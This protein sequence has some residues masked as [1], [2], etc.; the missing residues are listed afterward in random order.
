MISFKT[1][2]KIR[3][4]EWENT[5]LS[6][7]PARPNIDKMV[8]GKKSFNDLPDLLLTFYN[9]SKLRDEILNKESSI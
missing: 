6:F 3:Y 4:P 5:I 9:G 1:F 7:E 8:K 2:L